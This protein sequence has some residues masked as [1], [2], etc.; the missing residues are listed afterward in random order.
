M[1]ATHSKQQGSP[2]SA[3]S[4]HKGME[5]VLQRIQ[6]RIESSGP[7]AEPKRTPLP[8]WNEIN[9]AIPNHLARSSLFAPVGRGHRKIH[10]KILLSSRADAR[11]FFWGKQLDEADCDVWMQA[12][13]EARLSPLGIPVRINRAAFLRNIGRAT[14]NQNYRWLHNAFTRLA[15]GMLAIETQKY[16]IGAT[17]KGRVMHLLDGFDHD[18]ETDEYTLRIDPRMLNLFSCREFALIDWNKRMQITGRKDMA[19]YLQRFVATSNDTVQRYA[20]EDLKERML[21]QGRPRDF[22]HALHEALTELTRV[23]LVATHRFEK[24]TRGRD[25]IVIYRLHPSWSWT[26]GTASPR[27]RYSIALHRYSIAT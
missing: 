26:F 3:R 18:P 7:A 13:H 2:T 9:R 5:D 22:K 16:T 21:Y 6:K 8:Y 4:I 23:G 1:S 10:D 12:L 19:K 20:L 17:S 14:G 11:I 27:H 25:Q 24:S 15:Y